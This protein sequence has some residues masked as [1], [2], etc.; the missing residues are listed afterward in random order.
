MESILIFQKIHSEIVDFLQRQ[1][2]F[3]IPNGTVEISL[4]FAKFSSFQSLLSRKQLQMV[5]AI[6]LGWFADFGKTVTNIHRSYQP[7]YSDK[8]ST[9]NFLKTISPNMF[10]P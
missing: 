6:S 3:S 7:V 2:S 10:L 9:P 4:Q 8:W 1:S 5:S